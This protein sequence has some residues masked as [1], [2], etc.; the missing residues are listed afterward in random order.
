MSDQ[1][2]CSWISRLACFNPPVIPL[3]VTGRLP[4]VIVWNWLLCQAVPSSVP[5]CPFT[6]PHW[7]VHSQERSNGNYLLGASLLGFTNFT[8]LY[9]VRIWH[10]L[11]KNEKQII[12]CRKTY[13]M[14]Q[15][16]KHPLTWLNLQEHLFVKTL[17]QT[18]VHRRHPRD[19]TMTSSP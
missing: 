19:I 18:P 6:P 5:C 12:K 3:V 10:T 2:V 17:L 16:P 7:N 1:S 8:L 4:I 15:R 13:R 9:W 11:E 14:E